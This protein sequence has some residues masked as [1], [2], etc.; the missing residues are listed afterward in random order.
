[1]HLVTNAVTHFEVLKKCLKIIS[2]LLKKKSLYILI[3]NYCPVLR[4]SVLKKTKKTFESRFSN[5]SELI[6]MSH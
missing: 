5:G 1:M 4:E 6:V 2:P 3:L